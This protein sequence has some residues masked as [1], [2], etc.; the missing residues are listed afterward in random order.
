MKVEQLNKENKKFQPI[1]LKIT[2]ESEQELASLWHRMNCN[3]SE[4]NKASDRVL[5]LKC[6]DG[7]TS[8]GLFELLDKLAIENNLYNK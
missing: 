5:K 4:I 6:A 3:R 7:W 8:T 2:I 1:E